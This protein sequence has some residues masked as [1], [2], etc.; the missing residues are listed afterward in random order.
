MERQRH[1]FDFEQHIID[2]YNLTKASSYTS[3]FDAYTTQTGIPVSIKCIKD[4]AEICLGDFFRQQNVRVDFYLVVGFWSEDGIKEY[5]VL[6]DPKKWQALL[7]Q[8]DKAEIQNFLD[9]ISNDYNDDS[10]WKKGIAYFKKKNSIVKL[11]FKRDHKKQKR[12]QCAIRYK[13]FFDFILKLFPT[14]SPQ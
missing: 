4:G 14:R 6:V 2:K 9:G 3:V 12:V 13:D 1:G 5:S 7:P 11:R 10:K 8:I